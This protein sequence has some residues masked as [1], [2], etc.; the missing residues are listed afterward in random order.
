[1]T[2]RYNRVF[3]LLINKDELYQ[4]MLDIKEKD[5]LIE[6]LVYYLRSEYK[7]SIEKIRSV[8]SKIPEA[9]IVLGWY[10][11]TGSGV[12][13]NG[14]EAKKY[15]QNAIDQKI[16]Y[17]YVYMGM[18][19]LYMENP[20]REIIGDNYRKAF[21]Y[22]WDVIVKFID[23]PPPLTYYFIGHM[24][25]HDKG[26]SRDMVDAFKAL[27]TAV[28]NN[29]TIAKYELGNL[30]MKAQYRNVNSA[31]QLFKES[32]IYYPAA[33]SKLSKIYYDGVDVEKNINLSLEYWVKFKRFDNDEK[34]QFFDT[35]IPQY[36]FDM[37]SYN[38]DLEYKIKKLKKVNINGIKHVGFRQAEAEFNS[39]AERNIS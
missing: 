23:N 10:Y 13:K 16:S 15:Y 4:Y 25:S 26:E 7:T 8:I 28:N 34:K 21:K 36:V 3:D 35:N 17:G 32:S 38:I 30:Y 37:V 31:I 20:D 18:L 1:M 14:E 11:A 5:E 24:I 9:N 33:Y 12:E 6:S 29:I 19:Y 2:Y 39:L 22:F 27:N